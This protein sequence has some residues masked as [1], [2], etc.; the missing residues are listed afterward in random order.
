MPDSALARM[1]L[2]FSFSFT[3]RWIVWKLFNTVEKSLVKRSRI[4]F[5]WRYNKKMC[6]V[7]F[8]CVKICQKYKPGHRD[9]SAPV[10]LS[11][12]STNRTFLSTKLTYNVGFREVY[13]EI[14]QY[15][16]VCRAVLPYV[17]YLKLKRNFYS[18]LRV[19]YYKNLF[20]FE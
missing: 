15:P 13:G 6:I 16:P 5:C 2:A 8:K 10:N 4:S 14:D 19:G 1:K 11:I 3:E 12:V 18:N 17:V 20:F 9:L 7:S